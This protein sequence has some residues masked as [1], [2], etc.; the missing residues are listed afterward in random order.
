MVGGGGGGWG[1]HLLALVS[2]ILQGYPGHDLAA[3]YQVILP[4]V[5]DHLPT[6]SHKKLAET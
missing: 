2:D 1:A 3:I 4:L 5:G 6:I